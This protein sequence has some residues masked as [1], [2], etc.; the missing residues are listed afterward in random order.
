MKQSETIEKTDIAQPSLYQHAAKYGAIIG[1]ISIFLVIVFYVVNI[2]FLGSFKF[3]I[4]MLCVWVASVIYAG[5]NYRNEVGGYLS[6]GTALLHGFIALAISGIIS[7]IFNMVL[8]HVIDPELPLKL[9]AAIMQNTEEMMRNL[10]A[11]E[12]AIE[13]AITGMRDE[14]PKQFTMVGMA[15]GCVKA[16]IWYAGVVVITSLFVRKNVPVE[17]Q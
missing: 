3:L 9:T 14:L 4:L 10:G 12:G 8:Y 2:L 7:T 11:P 6:Y 15:F 17:L 13:E 16:F 5:I 1:A